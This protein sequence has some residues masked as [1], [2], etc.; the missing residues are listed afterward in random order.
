M[1]KESHQILDLV[2]LF[3][4]ISK[5]STEVRAAEIIPEV[6]RKAFKVARSEKP[7]AAFISL[8]ENIAGATMDNAEPLKVQ[9]AQ[10]PEP[11]AEKIAKA[12]QLLSE[13]RFPLVLAGNGVVRARASEALVRFAERLRVP[14]VTTFMAKGAIPDSHELSLG[15]VGL[16]ATDYISCGFDRAD[17]VLCVG[18]DIVEY[19]PRLWNQSGNT[20]IIH[21]DSHPPRSMPTIFWRPVSW[22]TSPQS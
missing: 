21:I 19:H 22:V 4:P 20:K 14:V 3:E 11:P 7:G 8:P 2:S 16:A 13:A 15:T 9:A 18:Y 17:V 6:V 10:A 5:Y 1:H 12:V